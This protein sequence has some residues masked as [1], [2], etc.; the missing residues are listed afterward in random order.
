MQRLMRATRDL[1]ATNKSQANITSF[2]IMGIDRTA[3]ST[4]MKQPPIT[5]KTSAPQPPSDTLSFQS[6]SFSI[7]SLEQS[8]FLSEQRKCCV[9]ELEDHDDDTKLE[10]EG[11]EN[12]RE[13]KHVRLDTSEM[14]DAQDFSKLAIEQKITKLYIKLLAMQKKL[15]KLKNDKNIWEGPSKVL[16]NRSHWAL[17]EMAVSSA[18]TAKHQFFKDEVKQSQKA[19]WDIYTLTEWIIG[20]SKVNMSLKLMA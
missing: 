13:C 16:K 9:D 3:L 15:A 2:I 11:C 12:Q 18:L 14:A 19:N 7:S 5:L 20:D 4:A 10:H 1:Y 17:V 6:S 8:P